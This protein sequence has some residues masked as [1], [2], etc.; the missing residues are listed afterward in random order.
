MRSLKS[1]GLT[2]VA[3]ALVTLAIFLSE[4]KEPPLIADQLEYFRTADVILK[5]CSTVFPE[6]PTS[7]W[8]FFTDN[9]GLPVILAY[10]F[11]FTHSHILTCRLL[12][13][14]LTFVYLWSAWLLC[15]LI[16]TKWWEQALY[17]IVSATYISYGF[18]FWG[19]TVFLASLSRSFVIPLLL[20][21]IWALLR[22]RS[23]WM[24][25][26]LIPTFLYG[27]LL[28]LSMVHFWAA[29]FLFE[30]LTIHLVDRRDRK[31]RLITV[32]AILPLSMLVIWHLAR[33][34]ASSFG[35]EIRRMK[36][37]DNTVAT[38]SGAK[39]SEVDRTS[40]GSSG[41]GQENETKGK[42]F[43]NPVPSVS[44]VVPAVTYLSAHDA[45]EVELMTMRWRNFP[46]SFVTLAQIAASLGF[47]VPLALSGW[48]VCRRLG[49]TVIDRKMV[50]LGLSILIVGIAPQATIWALRHFAE[51]Y[52]INSEEMRI[53]ALFSIPLFYFCFRLASNLFHGA[54]AVRSPMI[55]GYAV[56]LIYIVQPIDFSF[57]VPREERARAFRFAVR[58]GY[59]DPWDSPR[60]LYARQVFGIESGGD[61]LY[62]SVRDVIGWLTIHGKPGQR[63]LAH[64]PDLALS[65]LTV[66][67]SSTGF[68]LGDN[69]TLTAKE[70]QSDM[71]SFHEA[72]SRKDIPRIM[73]IA[74]L[75]NADYIVVPWV[76]AS[77]IYK[78][79]YYSILLPAK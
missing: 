28:H 6:T 23:N 44:P 2:A 30:C 51:I 67:G 53:I 22:F 47:I 60:T 61:R 45:W 21:C 42:A 33:V 62:Y 18:T 57:L 74:R 56:L 58:R 52:P 10:L 64:R 69:R 48:V 54:V 38:T 24:R 73:T 20:L 76:D 9:Q 15:S 79:E 1:F 3:F 49:L 40:A 70:W 29:L 14:A 65:G 27:T 55:A 63:L 59:L 68:I 11:S 50:W 31:R 71:A 8:R 26:L 35:S 17:A 66:L 7:Y 46:F 78:G 32:L 37:F 39:H 12:L 13:V 25:L 5:T 4:G 16:T 19:F 75:T 34:P 41:I 72:T 43:A 36:V 77:A